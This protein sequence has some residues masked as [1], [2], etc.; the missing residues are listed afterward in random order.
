MLRRWRV[1]RVGEGGFATIKTRALKR[2][3]WKK[4]LW[5]AYQRAKD[6]FT[7]MY[8]FLLITNGPVRCEK[9]HPGS[10]IKQFWGLDL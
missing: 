3:L 10:Q 4:L 6:S 9:R 5:P 2:K 1:I 8:F 7:I